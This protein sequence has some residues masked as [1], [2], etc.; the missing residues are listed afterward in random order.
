MATTDEPNYVSVLAKPQWGTSESG[1]QNAL[2]Q[3]LVSKGDMIR[4]EHVNGLRLIVD[5]IYNHTHTYTDS[6]GSC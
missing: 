2:G 5:L 6:V 3:P 1:T 4:A